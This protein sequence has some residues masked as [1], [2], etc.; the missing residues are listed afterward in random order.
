MCEVLGY[1]CYTCCSFEKGVPYP[2]PS[3]LS[4]FIFC[5]YLVGLLSEVCIADE[6]IKRLY[7]IKWIKL[8]TMVH[9]IGGKRTDAVIF[10]GEKY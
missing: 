3:S 5:W 10:R 1:S 7:N 8:P 9:H 2:F 6:I 4:D